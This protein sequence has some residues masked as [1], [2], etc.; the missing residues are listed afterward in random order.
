[1]E[2]QILTYNTHGLPWSTDTTKPICQW[3]KGRSPAIVC[4][5]EV[6]LDANRAYYREHLERAGYTVIVPHD[7]GVGCLNS[8][9]LTAVLDKAYV[10][11]GHRFTGFDD[12]HNVEQFSNKGFLAAR[13]C[14]RHTGRRLILINTHTQSSTFLSALFGE[15]SIRRVR[16]AQ[17]QQMLDLYAGMKDPALVVGDLNCE[18]SPHPYLRFL[19][20]DL[21][22]KKHTFPST[23]EDL[24][25]VAWMPLQWATATAFAAAGKKGS[26][27]CSFCDIDAQGPRIVACEITDVPWSDHLPLLVR[28][29]VPTMGSSHRPAS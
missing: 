18:I 11:E 13:L 17:I 19:Q 2:C 15:A 12:F 3:I 21:S 26:G 6:F 22:L 27:G 4:L 20:M 7:E 9:L 5:Q 8:G 10:V 29:L 28:V 25:H 16:R 1:M 14:C 23:G 24:D